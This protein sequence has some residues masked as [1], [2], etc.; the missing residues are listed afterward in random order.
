MNLKKIHHLFK[1][2]QGWEN[3]DQLE[4][5]P[6]IE[7]Q[8]T[9]LNLKAHYTTWAKECLVMEDIDLIKNLELI[10]KINLI[11]HANLIYKF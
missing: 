2:L 9:V 4:V 8:E 3:V 7:E 6:Q 5:S 10:D 11:F 1:A